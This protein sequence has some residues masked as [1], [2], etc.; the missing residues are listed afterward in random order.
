MRARLLAVAAGLLAAG[1]ACRSGPT[2]A[3]R[4][5]RV[6]LVSYD[7]LGA[8]LAWQWIEGGLARDPDGLAALA[9]SGL[10]LRRL[11]MVTPTLTAV[12]HT[13]LA[14]GRWPSGHGIVSNVFRIAGTPIT[15]RASGYSA[16]IA[17][18]TLWQAARRQGVPT[19]VI[20]WPGADGTAPERS[21][22][23]GLAWPTHPLADSALLELS[24]ASAV[25]RGEMPSHDGLPAL[26]WSVTADVVAAEIDRIELELAAVDGEED[27][28]ARYDTVLVRGPADEGFRAVAEL[29]WIELDLSARALGDE[30]PHRYRSW[31]KVLR[32]DRRTGALRLY[33]GGFWRT[34][35]YPESFADRLESELGPWPG[36]P[37]EHELAAWWLDVLEG[38]DLDTFLEQAERLDRWLDAAVEVTLRSEP[39]GLVLAYHPTP[40]EYQ[41]SSLVVEQNQWAWSPGKALA[42]AEG[43]KRIGRSVDRSVGDTARALD[44]GRDA[45]VVVSDHGLVPLHDVVH[46]N[47]ALAAAGLVATVGDGD[48]RRIAPGTPMLALCSGGA[49]HLYLSLVGREPDGV[50]SEAEAPELLRRAARALADLEVDGTPVVERILDRVQAAR[51]GLDHP[52]SGDLV[53]LLRPGF[54]ASSALSETAI[55]P[56]T[57][58]AQ[59]GYHSGHDSMCGVLLARGVAVPVERRAEMPAMAVAPL[60]ASLLGIE[61]PRAQPTD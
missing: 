61:P 48:G 46:V 51:E 9:R 29:G 1:L 21:G 58:Y 49:A 30:R 22:D 5:E 38:V 28:V 19:A 42:A 36:V 3:P 35:A 53:V 6:V 41:H 31:T 40:D 56:S 50:V 13:T 12:N 7:G 20:L 14:T 10:S 17:A 43:L 34:L 16:P 32:L 59:H 33:R 18:E 27:G 57:Y 37:D 25:V 60:V 47:T 15:E 44:L 52:S 54:A 8:D 55:A 26:G 2:V 39:A 24:A 45:L 23:V 11:R 4:A